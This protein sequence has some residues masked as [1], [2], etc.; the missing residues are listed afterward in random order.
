MRVAAVARC[1][2]TGVQSGVPHFFFSY[3]LCMRYK[4]MDRNLEQLQNF[5]RFQ[6]LGTRILRRPFPGKGQ[7]LPPSISKIPYW[8]KYSAV[9]GRKTRFCHVASMIFQTGFF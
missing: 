6:P 4:R 1:E 5:A 8:G 7:P 3:P 2:D 9:I